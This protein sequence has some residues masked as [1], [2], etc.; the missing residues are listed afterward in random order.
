[1][2]VIVIVIVQGCC[3][4]TFAVFLFP[5]SSSPPSLSRQNSGTG[6]IAYESMT[7]QMQRQMSFSTASHS[8]IPDKPL[9]DVSISPKIQNRGVEEKSKFSVPQKSQTDRY[10]NSLLTRTRGGFQ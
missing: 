6:V 2:I 9:A 10:L 3:F 7:P 5:M 1:V 4:S 8:I